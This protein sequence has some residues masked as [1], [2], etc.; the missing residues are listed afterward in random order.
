MMLKLVVQSG[1]EVILE[2]TD[3][4]VSLMPAVAPEIPAGVV[5]VR[6]IRPPCA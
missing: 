3:I 2:K 6:Q 4:G 1:C 5:P